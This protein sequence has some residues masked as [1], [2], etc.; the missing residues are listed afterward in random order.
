ML[1]NCKSC[2]ETVQVTTKL[3][4]HCKNR[5]CLSK[6]IKGESITFK[7]AHDESMSV[8]LKNHEKGNA[9]KLVR[10]V[11][12]RVDFKSELR[13]LIEDKNIYIIKAG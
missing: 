11:Y 10:N 13:R 12:F 4:M 2:G 8:L 5:L 3:T 1:I 6:F 7:D 9:F